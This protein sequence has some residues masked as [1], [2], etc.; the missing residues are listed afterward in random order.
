MGWL[1]G[2]GSGMGAMRWGRECAAQ[3]PFRWMGSQIRPVINTFCA[4]CMCCMLASNPPL[5]RLHHA[6]CRP[7]CWQPMRQAHVHTTYATIPVYVY[8]ESFQLYARGRV[9][10]DAGIFASINQ[11]KVL[12]LRSCN[13]DTRNFEVTLVIQIQ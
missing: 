7:S 4:L 8:L 6:P 10:P 12:A 11:I 9:H 3:P 2:V 1:G 13:M 5:N